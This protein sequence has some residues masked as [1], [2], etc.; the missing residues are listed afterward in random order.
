MKDARASKKTLRFL[1]EDT[2]DLNQ[3]IDVI[4]L[5]FQ[6]LKFCL[7]ETADKLERFSSFKQFIDAVEEVRKRIIMQDIT[8][9]N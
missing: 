5:D 6:D 3:S 7:K 1:I 8:Q 4:E 2:D 9:E